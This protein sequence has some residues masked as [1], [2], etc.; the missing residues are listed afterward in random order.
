MSGLTFKGGK[1]ILVTPGLIELGEI[2]YEENPL[3]LVARS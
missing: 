2:E 1:K 3:R